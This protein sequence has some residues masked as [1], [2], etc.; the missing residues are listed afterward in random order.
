MALVASDE[1]Q[2]PGDHYIIR[3]SKGDSRNAVWQSSRAVTV[4][5]PGDTLGMPMAG[6]GDTLGMH[7]TR[8]NALSF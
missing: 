1:L 7:L 6:P 8:D 4:A 3:R 2:V 5:G